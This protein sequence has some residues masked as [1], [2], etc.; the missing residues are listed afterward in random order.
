MK[1]LEKQQ[2]FDTLYG[3]THTCDF[4]SVMITILTSR[5][6]AKFLL[7]RLFYPTTTALT[8]ATH[9]PATTTNPTRPEAAG[10]RPGSAWTPLGYPCPPLPAKAPLAPSEQSLKGHIIG[11]FELKLHRLFPDCP[12]MLFFPCLAA[13][14]Q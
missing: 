5:V 6:A 3:N 12:T 11:V 1:L 8:S 2:W 7:L 10:G 13:L 4:S 14:I 9:P